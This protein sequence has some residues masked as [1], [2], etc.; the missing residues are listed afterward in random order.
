MFSGGSAG[1]WY[2][3]E[4]EVGTGALW[5]WG[6]GTDALWMESGHGYLVQG[7]GNWFFE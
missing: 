7:G 6:G 3:V 4:G 5:R 1:Y 2:P